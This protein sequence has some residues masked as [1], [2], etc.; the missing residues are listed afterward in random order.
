MSYN[1]KNNY[2]ICV[3]NKIAGFALINEKV[4]EKHTD[5]KVDKFFI[6]AKF[7]RPGI[8]KATAEKIWQI[9]HSKW[10]VSVITENTSALKF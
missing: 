10:E 6:L 7:Q 2:C 5:W 9:H 4:L 3:Y 8:G 1:S